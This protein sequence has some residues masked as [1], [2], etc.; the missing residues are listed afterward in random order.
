MSPLPVVAP[1]WVVIEKK[2]YQMFKILNETTFW[3]GLTAYSGPVDISMRR[4]RGSQRW[5]SWIKGEDVEMQL[6]CIIVEGQET[7]LF[8]V[9]N[10]QNMRFYHADI[11]FNLGHVV[12]KEEVKEDHELMKEDTDF[13]IDV[14]E[15][16]NLIISTKNRA[17][18]CVGPIKASWPLSE[19][20]VTS[21]V[22]NQTEGRLRDPEY[23]EQTG[24]KRPQAW[25]DLV[26]YVDILLSGTELG[27][28]QFSVCREI[29]SDTAPS[30]SLRQQLR[31]YLSTHTNKIYEGA[32][33]LDWALQNYYNAQWEVFFKGILSL[34]RLFEPVNAANFPKMRHQKVVDTDAV[35]NVA[36]TSWKSNAATGNT[37]P[38]ADN[39]FWR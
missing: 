24:N 11:K 30:E 37:T 36:L 17:Q 18:S 27:Y 4:I 2:Q 38:T 32:P 19:S 10:T 39:W 5:Y 13:K 26:R 23:G 31:D 14:F 16:Y 28:Q 9:D 25:S 35:V 12:L 15:D 1:T 7:V 33:E 34:V 6:V 29:I 21:Y 3:Q 22:I 8:R 20:S